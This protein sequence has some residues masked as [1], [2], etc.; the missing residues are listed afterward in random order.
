MN[1]SVGSV[2]LYNIVIV[3]LIIT[4]AFLAGAVSYSKAFRVN[5]RIVNAIEKYEGYNVKSIHEIDRVLNILGYKKSVGARSC[6]PKNGANAVSKSVSNNN[7][8]YCVYEYKS[9]KGGLDNYYW[10]VLTYMYVDIPIVGDTLEIPIFSTS[11]TFY[12][13]PM[14]FPY[15]D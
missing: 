5:S 3:F 14:D 4:F 9:T 13:F 8:I 15:Y 11:D 10:G 2:A 12:R 1:Q 6:P 7:Y